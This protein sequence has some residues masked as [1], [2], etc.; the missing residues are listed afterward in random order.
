MQSVCNLTSSKSFLW[1][2]IGQVVLLI[3]LFA[4]FDCKIAMAKSQNYHTSFFP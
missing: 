3:F 2:G 1:R 4:Q